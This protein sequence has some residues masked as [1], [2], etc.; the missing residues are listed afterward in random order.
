[1]VG[2]RH[3]WVARRDGSQHG[4]RKYRAALSS[5]DL[6]P[7]LEKAASSKRGQPG[8][9]SSS[10]LQLAAVPAGSHRSVN[11]AEHVEIKGGCK[12]LPMI[13]TR[14]WAVSTKAAA[15]VLSTDLRDHSRFL[16]N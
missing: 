9:I 3:E 16:D 15:V 11:E 7:A 14:S 5:Y 8:E 1:M 13:P 10:S 4:E 12:P 2:P 6:I